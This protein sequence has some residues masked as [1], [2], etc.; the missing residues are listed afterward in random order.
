MKFYKELIAE[1]DCS[2]KEKVEEIAGFILDQMEKQG[3]HYRDD[4]FE[5]VADN[6]IVELS[7]RIADGKMLQDAENPYDLSQVTKSAWQKASNIRDA[8]RK[9]FGVSMTGIE[10]FLVSTHFMLNE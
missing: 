1:R 6:H 4:S 2:N 5:K 9:R 8:V 10:T 3:I 7:V